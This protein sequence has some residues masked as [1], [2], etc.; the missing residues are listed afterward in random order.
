MKKSG[1][2]PWQ[3]SRFLPEWSEQFGDK[4]ITDPSIK[5][6]LFEAGKGLFAEQG[7]AGTSVREI[8]AKANASSTMIHHYFGSKAGLYR[9]ILDQFSTE[10]FETP[11]RMIEAGL[12]TREEFLLRL[13]L[14]ISETFRAL[15]SQAPIFRII[16][17]E[18]SEFA[19]LGHFHA[20]LITFLQDAQSK[21]FVRDS[22]S[23]EMATGLMLDRLGNQVLFATNPKYQGPN[24]LKDAAYK[25]EW[26]RANIDVL[27]HGLGG[28]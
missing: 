16:S 6:R 12:N 14:F 1:P 8:C 5:N 18:G 24:V 21:G 17:R 25:Q 23:P 26:L 7:Y 4:A 28:Q 9:A 3:R 11:I 19:D 27:L 13:E 22:L 10:T 2:K 20:A 15:I